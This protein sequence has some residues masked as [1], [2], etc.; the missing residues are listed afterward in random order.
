MSDKKRSTALL[1]APEAPYPMAGGGAIRTASLVEYLRDRYE[2]D[3]IVFRQPGA[4]DPAIAF[5]EGCV[6]R[7][8]VI[9]LPANGRSLPA[10]AVRNAG[11]VLRRVPPL[12]DRFAGFGAQI[13]KSIAGRR[14]EIGVV[15]H[16]WCAPYLEQLASVCNRTVLDLHNV[17]SRLHARCAEVDRG[18]AGFAH[19]IFRDAS[20]GLE[21]HW[22]PRFG[23]VLATSETDAATAR[24]I[25]PA[26]RVAVYR[27]ALPPT[28]QPPHGDD[29]AIVFSGNLEYHP[30]VQAVGFFRERIW[31][32]LRER[33]PQLIWRLV[34]KNPQAVHRYTAGD[35]RIEV[36]GA[37]ADS[38]G[39]LAHSR[40][41]VVPL[42]TGSGTRLKILEAWAAGLPVVSTTVGAEGLPVR[43]G[44]TALLADSPEAFADAVSRLLACMQLRQN[45][46]QSGRMLLDK[47]FTWVT[48]WA[49]L[50][51]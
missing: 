22:L 23:L 1:L 5:P 45:L 46:G 38:V 39:E 31:P 36:I 11:R 41:A 28:P 21:R 29:E 26:A 27:N 4:A 10:R 18:A 43:D 47:E 33:W 30:N 13:E 16:F 51:F 25:A 3:V 20:L 8:I 32:L 9:E 24:A 15:E 42:L 12:V 14:Y 2:L 17:E 49:K 34:G 7:V 6:R 44:E 40:I 35:S 50:D 48:A 19:R 37:V